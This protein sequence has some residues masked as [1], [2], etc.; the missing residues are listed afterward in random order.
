MITFT[1]ALD[2]YRPD[3]P[4][5]ERGRWT[6]EGRGSSSARSARKPR[7]SARAKPAKEPPRWSTSMS[8]R[9]R[10]NVAAVEADVKVA[11]RV[12]SK[13]KVSA[14]DANRA[15]ERT[16]DAYD[17]IRAL[18]DDVWRNPTFADNLLK[19]LTSFEMTLATSMSGGVP[20][21]LAITATGLYLMMRYVYR[22]VVTLGAYRGVKWP[23]TQT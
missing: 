12:L 15:A 7:P 17:K 5:D 13:P 23:G 4:R 3:Q 11:R 14:E 19:F 6:R 8:A 22:K 1:Q 21:G 20:W 18:D 16:L 2:K 10:E 9:V